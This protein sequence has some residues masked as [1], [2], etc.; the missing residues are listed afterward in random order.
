VNDFA[1]SI[2]GYI[3]LMLVFLA[4]VVLLGLPQLALEDSIKQEI[5][6]LIRDVGMMAAGY[7]FGR[8]AI[9]AGTTGNGS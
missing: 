3:C 1:W 4:L 5:V 2:V 7:A 9:N 6:R 8:R